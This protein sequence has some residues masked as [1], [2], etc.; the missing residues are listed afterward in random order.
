MTVKTSHIGII[1]QARMTSTRLPGKIFKEVNHKKLLAY[2]IERLKQTGHEVAIA[3]TVNNTDD[4]VCDFALD[5]N[6]PF[7]RGSENNVLSRFYETAAKYKFDTIVRVTSDCPLIDPN[8]ICSSVEKYIKINDPNVY[9]SNALQ[10]TYARGFDFEIFSMQLLREAYIKATDPVDLEHVTP[11]IW[12]NRNG[13]VVFEHIRQLIDNSRFRITVDTP[14]DFDLIRI[15][16]EDYKAD[17]LSHNE[18]ENILI[19]HPELVSVNAHIEQKK[20]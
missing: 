10:R 6:I 1:T 3:T 18:I 11:Y 14:E 20:V 9:M 8:L 16:I 4:C 15:L 19:Q 5:Q 13:N 2:H 7:H 17:S 12:K